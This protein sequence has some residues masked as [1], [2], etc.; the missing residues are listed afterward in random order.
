MGTQLLLKCIKHALD[1]RF[2][3]IFV[4][5]HDDYGHDNHFDYG[6]WK[7]NKGNLVVARGEKLSKLYL[8]KYLVVRD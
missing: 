4:H 5:M 7:L 6:K 8:T 2:N 1:A 3:L